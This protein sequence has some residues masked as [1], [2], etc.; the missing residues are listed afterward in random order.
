MQRG[1]KAVFDVLK[2]LLEWNLISLKNQIKDFTITKIIMEKMILNDVKIEVEKGYLDWRI[3]N[4]NE[5][6]EL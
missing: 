2:E 1:N 3:I 4:I 6:T 5:Q